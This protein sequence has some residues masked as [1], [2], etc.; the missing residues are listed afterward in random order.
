[1]TQYPE[2][3]LARELG[4][5]YAAIGLVTDHDAGVHEDA[6]IEPVTQEAVFAEFERHLPRLREVVCRA[7]VAR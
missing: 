1:M 2:A 4:L 5:A 3:V 6:S 7:A